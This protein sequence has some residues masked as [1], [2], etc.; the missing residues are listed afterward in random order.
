MNGVKVVVR[1]KDMVEVFGFSS[2]AE[3][4]NWFRSESWNKMKESYNPD[5]VVAWEAQDGIM[6]YVP[7]ADL[8]RSMGESVE[9]PV[10]EP[11]KQEG[12]LR[13]VSDIVGETMRSIHDDVVGSTR[14]T[15]AQVKESVRAIGDFGKTQAKGIH[16][17]IRSEF[18]EAFKRS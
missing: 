10:V 6:L 15:T 1:I 17:A 8:F 16:D 9:K 12:G 18:P 2:K 13:P 4:N 11:K 5:I 7:V 14:E 3:A